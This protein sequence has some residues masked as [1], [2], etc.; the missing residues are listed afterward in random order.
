MEIDAIASLIRQASAKLPSSPTVEQMRACSIALHD[1]LPLPE[2]VQFT[3]SSDPPGLWSRPPERERNAVILY[4]HGGGYVLNSP[5]QYRMLTGQL[6]LETGVDVFAL[7]YRR[8]PEAPYPAALE[9]ALAAYQWLRRSQ[10]GAEVAI[11]GDSAGGGLALALML[12]CRKHGAAE[13]RSAF[14]MSPWADLTMSGTTLHS[15]AGVDPVV[16]PAALAFYATQYL[17]GANARDPS[18]SP[19]FG[20]LRGLPP[21]LIHVGSEEVLLDDS[22]RLAA[23]AGTAKVEVTLKVW[24]H[25]IHKWHIWHSRLPAAAAALRSAGTFIRE[26]WQ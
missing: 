8:A 23:A 9:D 18:V 2:N 10:H 5:N 25:M 26:H 15:K 24:P 14:L 12:R 22:L 6:C 11:A 4:L 13:P 19:I 3:E 7:Q 16:T 20:D 17:H 21:L 1:S